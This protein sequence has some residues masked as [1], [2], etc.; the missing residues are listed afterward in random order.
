[1]L[2]VKLIVSFQFSLLDPKSDSDVLGCFQIWS[3]FSLLWVSW[4]ICKLAEFSSWFGLKLNLVSPPVRSEL[5]HTK[6]QLLQ[7]VWNHLLRVS[8]WLFW[9]T[10]EA[11]LSVFTAAQVIT[12]IIP[13]IG[14]SEPGFGLT[15]LQCRFAHHL[16]KYMYYFKFNHSNTVNMLI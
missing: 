5:F 3:L 16:K 4:W 10:S 7:F 9:S 6:N 14:G 2:A 1:M 13:T 11:E 12:P 15:R 8:V